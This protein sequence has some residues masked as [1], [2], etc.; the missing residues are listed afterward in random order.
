MTPEAFELW[1][2]ALALPSATHDYL[3]T[4]RGRLPV[5][6]VSSRAGNV[7][8]TYPSRKMGVTIQFES[9]KVE[10][11][12]ILVMDQDPEVLEFFD[13]PDTFKLCYPGT[14]TGKMQGH[15]YTP[16]FLVLRKGSVCF[17]EWKSESDLHRLAQRSPTRY[18]PVEGGGWRCPPAEEATIPLGLP[19]QV[20]SSAE[21]D[22]TYIDNLIFLEDYLSV[23]LTVPAQ[24]HA[25]VLQRIQEIP[26]LPLAALVGDGSGARPHDIYALLAQN[27]LYADLY[28]APL[29]E[30]RHVRLYLSADQARAYAHRLPATLASR[31][32]SPLPEV[33]PPLIPNTPLLW[34]GLC[35]TLINPGETTTTLLSEKGQ[36]AQIPSSLF[37]RALDTGEI[38]PLGVTSELPI[39]SPEVDRRLS[40]ASP[41]DLR[42]ANERYAQVV[43]YLQG[44]KE[45]YA[46]TPP[47]TLHRWVARW[48]SAE[49]TLGC[50]Y[51]GLLSR[52]AAQGNRTPKAPT[53]PRELMDTFITELF[54]TPRKA[55]AAAVYRAYEQECKKRNFTALSARA[56]YDRIKERSGPEQTEA[57]E[58]ARAAYRER[59]WYW[60]LQHDTPRH[61]RRPFEIVH[62]DHTELDIEVRSSSTG[63]LLGKPWVTFMMDAYS[64]RLLAAYLTFDP[65][66]YRSVMMVLRICVQRFERFPQSIIVDGGKEFHSVYFESLLAQYRCTKK[67]RPWAQPHFG[68]V[69]ERLFNTTNEQFVYS[70]LGNTQA[71]KRARLMTRAVDPR[72]HALW[73]L[74]DL[75][76]YLVEYLYVI[77]DQNEHSSLGMSP[78]AAYLW[79]MRQGG[80][81]EHVRVAYT[82][83]FLKETC[84]TTA[85]GTAM[86]QKGS[87]IK[88]N[89]FYYWNNAFRSGEV[90]KTSVPIRF[91]PFDISTVYAQVQGQWLT[92]RSSYVTLEGHTERELFLA[93]QELRQSARRDGKRAEI[94]AARLAEH[95]SKAGTH[96]E[97]LRQRWSDLEGKKVFALIAGQSGHPQTLGGM[98]PLPVVPPEAVKEVAKLAA[99]SQPVDVSRL[100]RLGEY[101]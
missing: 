35:W 3:A 5:R 33:T 65:P 99:L 59:P 36:P 52:K 93:T 43:A 37:F 82:D 84:P 18:Q 26:G 19:F 68:S 92:C 39:T 60:E 21:L 100:K 8:G 77:Y 20:R 91:D 75:Y 101:R 85:K 28:A 78:Q 15:Y 1:C 97:L 24:V 10:L 73:T 67:Y 50:G 42:Q 41:E 22:P 86:I 17:E 2:R 95:M 4:I 51:V 62:I 38:K 66:S 46:K 87:G 32:G 55:P 74:P 16:D 44:E 57:R 98:I 83:R 25:Y 31:V 64:R 7:S 30:H 12:A 29:I 71:A 23:P 80:E 11:W 27:L 63:Q 49:A 48:R 88:V 58:G 53:E 61:G 34:D 96:E 9:H 72:E 6:R 40:L 94:S 56:F 14:H 81:R 47:R 79:G 54:E 76:T 89:H 69:I 45:T 90:V 70:L 13:Q